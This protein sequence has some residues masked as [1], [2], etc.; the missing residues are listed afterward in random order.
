MN[1]NKLLPDTRYREL[2]TA[3][4]LLMR[5]KEMADKV[6]R[7]GVDVSADRAYLEA[8]EANLLAWKQEFFSDKA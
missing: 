8:Q 7:C 6:E 4:G 5:A 2:N 1:D 3:L